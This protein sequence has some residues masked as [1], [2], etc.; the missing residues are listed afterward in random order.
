MDTLEKQTSELTLRRRVRKQIMELIGRMD[1]DFSTRLLSEPQLAAKLQV[2]RSTIRAVLTELEVEGKVIR[3][4]GSGTYV[5]PQALDI[6]TT[7][8]PRVNMYELI[9]KNGYKPHLQVTSFQNTPAGS[10]GSKLNILPNDL[11]TEVHSIYSADD[12]PCMYCIDCVDAR[13]MDGLNWKNHE[14]Y[15]ESIH[16][17][18][19]RMTQVNIA[20]DIIRIRSAHS[21][22]MP[23]L[24]ETF[25]VPEGQIKPLVLLEIINF[26]IDNQP[27]LYGNIYLDA[28]KIQLNIARDLSKL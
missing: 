18:I 11:V 25:R 7:I 3:R 14:Q 15:A 9:C 10:R 23:Q 5:N 12:E 16:D 1:F 24:Q 28:D 27:A 8:Y 6:E 13:R 26:D 4:H 2:S 22:Q 17:F 21:G 19:R 20:W